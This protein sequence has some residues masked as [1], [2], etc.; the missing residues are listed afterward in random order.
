MGGVRVHE[1]HLQTEETR[2]WLAVDELSA[3]LCELGQLAAQVADLV[4][5]VVHPRS[6]FREEAA[7][8]GVLAQR[9]EELDAAVAE[10]QRRG[11]HPLVRDDRSMLDVRAEE[12]PVRRDGLIEVGDGEAEMVNREDTHLRRC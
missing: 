2:A 9:R 10:A 7:H 5:D 4:S 3:L 8:G 1:R 6:A 12:P 11:L